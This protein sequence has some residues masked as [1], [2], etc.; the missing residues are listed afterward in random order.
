[1]PQLS[2]STRTIE[3][4]LRKKKGTTSSSEAFRHKWEERKDRYILE[5][6]RLFQQIE[7]WI[8]KLKESGPV[9]YRYGKP[10]L[11]YG[12]SVDPYEVPVLEVFLADQLVVFRPVGTKILGGVG[13]VDIFG[14]Y[15]AHLVMPEWGK[16]QFW[17]K[18]YDP[19]GDKPYTEFTEWGFKE[20]LL[21][22]VDG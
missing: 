8:D 18:K 13:R 21:M 14:K 17:W 19:I 7:E 16:W 3:E 2:T 9:N 11:I 1:M 20:V 15:E 6:N 22:L 4:F 10:T 5:V 12:E